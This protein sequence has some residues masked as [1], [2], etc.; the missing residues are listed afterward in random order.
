MLMVWYCILSETPML[1]A[2]QIVQD[3]DNPHIIQNYELITKDT[4]TI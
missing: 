1:E 3:L 2:M 4:L